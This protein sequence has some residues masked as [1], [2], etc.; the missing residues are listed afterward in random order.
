MNTR[1]KSLR[2]PDGRYEIYQH[3]VGK[4][5]ISFNPDDDR[6]YVHAAGPDMDVLKTYA[7]LRN[8]RAFAK[9]LPQ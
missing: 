5:Q 9:R 2:M 7:E 8:A 6:F 3:P 1:V 4:Y